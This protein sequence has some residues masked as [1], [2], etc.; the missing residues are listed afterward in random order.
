MEDKESSELDGTEGFLVPPPLTAIFCYCPML[1]SWST[2]SVFYMVSDETGVRVRAHRE[3]VGVLL[4]HGRWD[5]EVS[6]GAE[7]DRLR[8]PA[9]TTVVRGGP[10]PRNRITRSDVDGTSLALSYPAWYLIASNISNDSEF[11]NR[12]P[13]HFLSTRSHICCY[14]CQELERDHTGNIATL[15]LL[16]DASRCIKRY[17]AGV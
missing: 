8:R 9:T 10:P 11:R 15:A 1:H 12:P 14:C 3:A 16:C 4:C 13:D 17:V 7:M 5:G 6:Q 2:P